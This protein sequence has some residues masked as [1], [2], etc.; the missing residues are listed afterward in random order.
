[1]SAGSVAGCA[2]T[3]YQC[4]CSSSQSAIIQSAAQNCVITSC[5]ASA[6]SVLGAAA[7][8]CACVSA[9]PT[10]P[11]STGAAVTSA[12]SGTASLGSSQTASG[13]APG[14]TAISSGPSATAPLSSTT[15]SGPTSGS[16]GVTTVCQ[17]DG[18]ANCATVAAAVPTCAVSQYNVPLI[19]LFILIIDHR[20]LAWLRLPLAT[21][22]ELRI[23]LVNA[24]HLRTRQF[25][26]LQFLV[27]SQ[28]VQLRH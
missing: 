24:I 15:F 21:D 25:L 16:G 6:G 7:S 4:Q 5:G 18:T 10:T 12:G 20:N 22:A 26:M 14:S 9:S 2:S 8:L 13:S 23:S 19:S 17:T 27:L 3:D 28:R 1:M 11:C